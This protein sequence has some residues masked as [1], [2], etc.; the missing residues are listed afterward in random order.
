MLTGVGQRLG[1]VTHEVDDNLLDLEGIDRG[2]L[3]RDPQLQ[4]NDM[5]VEFRLAVRNSLIY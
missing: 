5:P 4:V 1:C 2:Q 3:V